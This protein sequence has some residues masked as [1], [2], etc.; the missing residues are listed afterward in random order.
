M[1]EGQAFVDFVRTLERLSFEKRSGK[2]FVVTGENH[3][4]SFGL[5]RGQIISVQY[6]IRRGERALEYFS[7]EPV[8][9]R[10]DESAELTIDP[11]LPTT[12]DILQ[13]LYAVCS[14]SDE[15]KLTQ[16]AEPSAE[17]PATFRSLASTIL[18][19]HIGP[20]SSLICRDVFARAT[21][22][23]EAIAM[24]V[25]GIPDKAMAAQFE[26]DM[27]QALGT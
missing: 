10:F 15:L 27:R 22:A 8:R 14:L 12:S 20:M 17:L 24:I 9:F 23:D 1:A 6:R 16:G 18:T 13:R 3:T 4:A 19:H 21:S 25:A 11:S 5:S 7:N 26:A 2:M